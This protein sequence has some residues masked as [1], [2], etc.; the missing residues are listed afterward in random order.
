MGSH[1]QNTEVPDETIVVQH[2]KSLGKSCL[3][4][5]SFFSFPDVHSYVTLPEANPFSMTYL[6]KKTVTSQ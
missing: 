4:G 3:K 6:K 1:V 5:L 2:G